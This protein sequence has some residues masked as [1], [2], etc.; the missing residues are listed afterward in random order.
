MLS[1]AESAPPPSTPTLL[2]PTLP[3]EFPTPTGT[4]SALA[5]ETLA[6]TETATVPLTD[7]TTTALLGVT[8]TPCTPPV[9]WIRI[10][11]GASDTIYTVAQRYKTS[12]ESLS[13]AN[14]LLS[15]DLPAGFA[16]YVPPVPTVTVVPCGPPAGWVRTYIVQ[17]GDTLFRIALAYGI[18]YPQLQRGNCMGSSTI[19]Y[20]GQRLWV[21]N[22]PTR[23]PTQGPPTSTN[24]NTSTPTTE[25]P[26]STDT[27]TPTST[28]T[29]SSTPT[30]TDTPVTP[31]S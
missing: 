13:A 30:L 11:T 31:A 12:A 8:S 1:L 7:T 29:P 27:A 18:T 16:L 17:P 3:Q 20:S 19:I 21:P 22:V 23:T 4:P 14:C 2:P 26:T 24:T 15:A 6:V 28:V 5:S 9:G 10:N 25:V